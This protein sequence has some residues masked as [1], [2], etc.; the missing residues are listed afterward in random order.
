[1][2]KVFMPFPRSQMLQINIEKKKKAQDQ[3]NWGMDGF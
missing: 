3:P 2:V 1:M